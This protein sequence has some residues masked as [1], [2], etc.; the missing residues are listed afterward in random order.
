[1]YLFAGTSFGHIQPAS[2]PSGGWPITTIFDR[3]EAAGI[4]WTFYYQISSTN[5]LASWHNYSKYAAE[6][7]VKPISAWFTDVQDPSK[8]AQVIFIERWSGLDEHPGSNI[9]K[10]A[11][12]AAKIINALMHSTSWS[13]SALIFTYDEGGGLYD[14]VLP[15]QVPAPDNIAP[16]YFSGAVP[17]D[18]KHTGFRVPMIV[19]SP[20]AKPNYVSHVVRD[21]TSILKLIETRF[22]VAP[23]GYRDAAADDMT[24]LF[25]F[26]NPHWLTPPAMPSQPTNGVCDWSKETA[27]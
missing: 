1:M 4:R 2:P 5:Y 20:W 15:P 26:T 14:H 6:G 23:L 27:P 13:S 22:G 11:A 10:G 18:F 7:R 12:Q 8:L 16:I 21:H 9:Q 19:F 17:G 25:D 3:L 24:E